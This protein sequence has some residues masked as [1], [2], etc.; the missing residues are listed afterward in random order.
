MT[1]EDTTLRI[2]SDLVAAIDRYLDSNLEV[3][4]IA[5]LNLVAFIG[6]RIATI[7]AKQRAEAQQIC[8]LCSN[9]RAWHAEHRPR[10][11]FKEKS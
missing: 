11:L 4:S 10:H 1:T 5:S 8:K 9:T 7:R 3:G 6:E 2:P